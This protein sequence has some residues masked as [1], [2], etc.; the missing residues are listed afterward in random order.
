MPPWN[1]RNSH[2]RRSSNT[3][4][5]T[6]QLGPTYPHRDRY[7][8]TE[9]D[10]RL[11]QAASGATLERGPPPNA[12]T[13]E[14]YDRRLRR[15]AETLKQ[16]GQSIARLDDDTLLDDAKKLLPND[17]VIGPALSMVSQFR[18]PD[19]TARPITSHYRPSKEDDQFIRKAAKAGF[20]RPM[21]GRNAGSYASNL[22]KL[23]EALRP[24]SIA[25]LSHDTLL[26]HADT[27]FPN[28]KKLIY[29]LNRL[30][31]Y[32]AIVGQD[33]SG[34]EGSTLRLPTQPAADLPAQLLDHEPPLGS[35]ADRGAPLRADGFNAPQVW[36]GMGLAA[37]SPAQ[38]VTQETV[39]DAMARS[40]MLP[41]A[42]FDAPEQMRS[43][44]PSPRKRFSRP[45]IA[46]VCCQPRL[47]MHRRFGQQRVRSPTRLCKL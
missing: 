15:L 40:S 2:E 29:A 19:P 32:R 11:I 8:I 35:T 18:E 13:V 23:A 17:K 25:K 26:G 14:F 12:T 42:S 22:R 20:G 9:E 21:D 38:R 44:T 24:L 4:E 34:G 47:S 33:N 28:D 45:R 36:Q 3:W 46:R 39:F 16:S 10:D 41:G 27:L 43:A 37:Y 7:D 5:K 30:R 6:R 1:S 31:D